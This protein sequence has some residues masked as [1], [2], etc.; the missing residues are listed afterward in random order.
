MATLGHDPIANMPDWSDG[1]GTYPAD[2]IRHRIFH[3][4]GREATFAYQIATGGRESKKPYVLA[5]AFYEPFTYWDWH[6][7]D[8]ANQWVTVNPEEDNKTKRRLFWERERGFR[9]NGGEWESYPSPKKRWEEFKKRVDDDNRKFVKRIAVAEWMEEGDFTWIVKELPQLEALDLGNVI[10]MPDIA[11]EALKPALKRLKWLGLTNAAYVASENAVSA[12]LQ[13]CPRLET[14]S[15]RTSYS[16]ADTFVNLL[17][18]KVSLQSLPGATIHQGVCQLI[19]IIQRYV[20]FTVKTLELRQPVPCIRFFLGQLDALKAKKKIRIGRV[21]IDLGAWIHMYPLRSSSSRPAIDIS[22]LVGSESIK[23]RVEKEVKRAIK[24]ARTLKDKQ[25]A[26]GLQAKLSAEIS[27]DKLS[28]EVENGGEAQDE[29][30]SQ[31]TY[32]TSR[33]NYYNHRYGTIVGPDWF[34]PEYNRMPRKEHNCPLDPDSDHCIIKD[35]IRDRKVNTCLRMLYSLWE[36]AHFVSRISLFGLSP[37]PE[38][39]S[40]EPIHPFALIQTTDEG[41][42]G[43]GSTFRDVVPDYDLTYLFS[44]LCDTFQWKPVFDWDCFMVPKDI[45]K[46]IDP[47]YQSV[48]TR[49]PFYMELLEEQ[50]KS[51]RRAGIPLHLVIGRR[52]P[53]QSSCYW[54]RP[55]RK[56]KW[57][58]WLLEKFDAN[59][60]NIASIVDSLSIL[61]DLRN[62]LS[63]TRLEEIEAA[64]PLI[65]SNARC[66]KV[67]CP[68]QQADGQYHERCPFKS[69][70]T[71]LGQPIPNSGGQKMANK[72][73]LNRRIHIPTGYGQLAGACDSTPPV[74]E[75]ANDH[76]SE[77]SDSDDSSDITTKVPLHHLGRRAVFAREAV[78]WQRFWGTYSLKFTSLTMLRVRMPHRFDRIGSW[79]LAKLLDQKNG[80]T[81]LLYTDERQPVQTEEDLVRHVGRGPDESHAFEHVHEAKSWP[82]GRFVRRSWIWSEK[83]TKATEHTRPKI[84]SKPHSENAKRVFEMEDLDSTVLPERQELQ[85]AGK[86]AESAARKEDE[87]LAQL[88]TDT[89]REQKAEVERRLAKKM[90]VPA[91]RQYAQQE[92]QNGLRRG[93]NEHEQEVEELSMTLAKPSAT[94]EILSIFRRQLTAHELRIA[95]LQSRMSED[96]LMSGCTEDNLDD[97][98]DSRDGVQINSDFGEDPFPRRPSFEDDT[99][100]TQA[101]T[102]PDLQQPLESQQIPTTLPRL[103]GL[104]PSNPTRSTT[105]PPSRPSPIPA[106]TQAATDP[107]PKDH[108]YMSPPQKTSHPELLTITKLAE[109]PSKKRKASS[110]E[111]GEKEEIEQPQPKKSRE[112]KTT[113]TVGKDPSPAPKP[114]PTPK[115]PT[116]KISKKPRARKKKEPSPHVQFGEL[117]DEEHDSDAEPRKKK[118]KGKGKGKASVKKRHSRQE[119]RPTGG[120]KMESTSPVARRTRSHNRK[121]EEEK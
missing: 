78:G 43:T 51:L 81:M 118:G 79:R 27:D 25:I 46:T 104:N 77:D 88:E 72:H 73:S 49:A 87:A 64:D 29:E 98:E 86:W 74:G 95:W 50:F 44:W 32:T 10:S 58:A 24:T 17:Q 38:E 8:S 94:K 39:R 57:E 35:T 113:S 92:W 83:G 22:R 82:A 48:L 41:G 7:K 62:P 61:Y 31:A 116:E 68:W 102:I 63:Q 16:D 34:S 90:Y 99:A 108:A 19:L 6:E 56:E 75:N 14:L 18:A 45:H 53:N 84:A 101:N 54:G 3:Y 115:V 110:A 13:S 106:N 91:M 120:R 85:A 60:E 59:L 89:S 28:V 52:N 47:A 42:I 109:S 26:D 23:A 1:K 15:L 117:D 4:A 37:E 93:I 69:H 36:A 71:P 121:K 103:D 12:I 20:P 33:P 55:Y 80:W 107:T 112:A 105:E 67:P 11:I 21:G 30:V 76:P 65:K 96:V 66:P 5:N 119:Y 9:V 97:G 40:L 114:S 70:R 2:K 100:S 111:P